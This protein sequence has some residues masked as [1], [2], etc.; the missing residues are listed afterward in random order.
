M[1]PKKIIRAFEGSLADAEGLLA[2]EKATFDEI[3]YTA[4]EIQAMLT[5]EAQRVWLAVGDDQVV[6]FVAAFLT[7]G[8]FGPSWEIDLLAV[9]PAWTGQGLGTRLIR[10][11][12]AQGMAVA[13]RARAVVATDNAASARA[14]ARVGFRRAGNCDLLI[15]RPEHHT[16]RPWTALGVTIGEVDSVEALVEWLPEGAA[17]R[18]AI[19]S[20]TSLLLAEHQGQPSGYAELLAVQTLLYQG[21]WIE[22]LAASNELVRLALIHETV[23]RAATAGLDEIGMMAPEQDL[24]LRQTLREAGFRSLGSFDWFVADLPLPGLAAAQ[25]GP[26]GEAHV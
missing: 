12:A 21:V 17:P 10:K 8:L 20:A 14:F 19:G 24:P 11:A 18:P 6:G 25:A 13:R 9:K 22:S 26:T 3:P 2:V 7:S 4:Q 1:L 15:Y 5:G 16:P 23:N